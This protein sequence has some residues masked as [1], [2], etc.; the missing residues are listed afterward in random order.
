MLSNQIIFYSQMVAITIVVFNIL[1]RVVNVGLVNTI[2]FHRNSEVI[3][4]IMQFIFVQQF[5]NTAFLLLVTNANFE[6]TPLAFIYPI[7]NKY[8]DF[9]SE[10]YQ[11]VGVSIYKTMLIQAFM[12]YF[13]FLMSNA[14]KYVKRFIDSGFSCRKEIPKTKKVTLQQFVEL[15][16]GTEVV[17]HFKYA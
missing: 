13:Q 4:T 12:P 14:P 3:R 1:L 10:W 16:S 11:I 6:H 7:R 15:Y 5:I 9:S 8:N 2:G 17:L